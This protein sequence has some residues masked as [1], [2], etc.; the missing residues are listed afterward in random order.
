MM[1]SVQWMI[2]DTLLDVGI[3]PGLLGWDYLKVGVEMVYNDREYLRNM[4]GKLYP[5]IAKEVGSTTSRVERAIRH[6]IESAF[7]NMTEDTRKKYFGN[8]VSMNSGKVTNTT[9]I[10]VIVERI[11]N[12]IQADGVMR[13]EEHHNAGNGVE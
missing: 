8:V 3:N 12:S 10:A 13:E 1:T 2:S 5:D 6:A 4:T 9:F 11:Q 7:N